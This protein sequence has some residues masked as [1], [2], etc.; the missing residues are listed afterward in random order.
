MLCQGEQ[1]T[2]KVNTRGGAIHWQ[3]NS[4][5]TIFTV[6]KA[7]TYW[8]RISNRCGSWTDSVTISER[9][10]FASAFLP[11][12]VTPNND[13][14]ND[15]FEPQGLEAGIWQ[16]EV[17]NRWGVQVY[18]KENYTN[19]WPD[20]KLSNGTY[21]YLLRNKQTGKAYKGWVDVMGN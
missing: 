12:I 10:C 19:Q 15:T 9:R 20:K 2:L 17:Y 3:D 11:N 14:L 1:L 16:L 8:V 4:T 5:D 18:Q 13:N 6:T 21:Y 7:G